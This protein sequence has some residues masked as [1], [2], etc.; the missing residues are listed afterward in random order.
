M[1]KRRLLLNAGHEMTWLDA[2]LVN[3]CISLENHVI[4]HLYHLGN[5]HPQSRI[6]SV[7]LGQKCAAFG[8]QVSLGSLIS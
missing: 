6:K 2:R 1:E 8:I 7:F 3:G 5:Y 4:T